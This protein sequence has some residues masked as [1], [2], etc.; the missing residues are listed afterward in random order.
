MQIIILTY[1]K[2]MKPFESITLILNMFYNDYTSKILFKFSFDCD[3]GGT[4]IILRFGGNIWID[5]F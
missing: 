5:I 4:N 3:Y 1:F 2:V